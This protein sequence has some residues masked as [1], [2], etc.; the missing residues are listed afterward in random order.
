MLLL[1]QVE[2]LGVHTVVANFHTSE[3][4]LSRILCAEP[5][6]LGLI[7]M[8]ASSMTEPYGVFYYKVELS[9]L[10]FY[11]VLPYDTTP[12]LLR[13]KEHIFL[14]EFLVM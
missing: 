3:R 11:I 6:T 8:W 7:W 4:I 2:L 12:R 14:R 1:N 9:L 5:G 10:K 13:S